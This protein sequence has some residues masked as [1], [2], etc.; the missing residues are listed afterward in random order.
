M[1]IA[2]ELQGR[3]G[4]LKYEIKRLLPVTASLSS[5]EVRSSEGERLHL[6]NVVPVIAG[7]PGQADL[8]HLNI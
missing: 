8:S 4:L 5:H 1:G 7:D 6:L 2:G 3:M